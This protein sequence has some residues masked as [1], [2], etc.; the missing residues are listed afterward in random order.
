MWCSPFHPHVPLKLCILF[1]ILMAGTV[2]SFKR[3]ILRFKRLGKYDQY[4]QHLHLLAL[5]LFNVDALT[6]TLYL[7]EMLRKWNHRYSSV[8]MFYMHSE[9]CISWRKP[10]GAHSTSLENFKAFFSPWK[11]LIG[12]KS[13]GLRFS[14]AQFKDLE[15]FWRL[16]EL[17]LNNSSS[18]SKWK[19]S[20]SFDWL[21]AQSGQE[22]ISRI[23]EKL[24]KLEISFPF[25]IKR[26]SHLK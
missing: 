17:K 9:T 4:S 12:S 11:L 25:F 5:H 1:I 23:K 2:F 18:R 10:I 13:F 15:K 19:S 14:N 24:I 26:R 7:H 21:S 20:H 16:L 3:N 22:R 6:H 8:A